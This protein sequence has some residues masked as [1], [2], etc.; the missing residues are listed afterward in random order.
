LCVVGSVERVGE[1]GTKKEAKRQAAGAV[2]EVI[3]STV[4]KIGDSEDQNETK[5]NN[6]ENENIQNEEKEHQKKEDSAFFDNAC[7][8]RLQNCENNGDTKQQ[9]GHAEL[10]KEVMNQKLEELNTGILEDHDHENTPDEVD[11]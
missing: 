5:V 7:L 9:N 1:G 4:E 6:D 3:S 10:D 2:L 11:E 8:D